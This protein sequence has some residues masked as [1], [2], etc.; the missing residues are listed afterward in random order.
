MDKFE[1]AD[2]LRRED[3]RTPRELELELPTFVLLG[4]CRVCGAVFIKPRIPSN[5]TAHADHRVG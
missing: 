5:R 1:D 4:R 2:V 3:T